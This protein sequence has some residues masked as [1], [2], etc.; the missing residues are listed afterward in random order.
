MGADSGRV[1]DPYGELIELAEREHGLIEARDY[2]GLAELIAVRGSLMAELPESAPAE[3][4]DAIR[5]LIELQLRNDAAMGEATRG[6]GVEL[7]RLVSGRAG[8]RRYAPASPGPN[9][10]FTA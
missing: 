9:L 2:A 1:A 4:H 7:Q 3:V 5:R 6:L 8:V 10:D